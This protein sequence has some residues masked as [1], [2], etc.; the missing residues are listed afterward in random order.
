VLVKTVYML[1]TSRRHD[2]GRGDVG[3]TPA[4]CSVRMPFHVSVLGLTGYALMGLSEQKQDTPQSRRAIPLCL[5]A[6]SHRARLTRSS[7]FISV[8]ELR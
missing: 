5:L 7:E 6:I 1:I 3:P 8:S 2:A 4:V